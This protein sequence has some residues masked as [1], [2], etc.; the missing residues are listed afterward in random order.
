MADSAPPDLIL[1]RATVSLQGIGAGQVG[2]F[3]PRE[4]TNYMAQ[5][6]L[7]PVDLPPMP[8]AAKPKSSRGGG[9][10]S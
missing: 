8:D 7:I 6:Y 1:M 2:Y 5:G 3:D 4:V 10:A 9:T